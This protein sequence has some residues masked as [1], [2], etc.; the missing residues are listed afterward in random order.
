MASTPD[1]LD[2]RG[3]GQREA[4]FQFDLLDTAR[5]RIGG[6]AP[7]VPVDVTN[8]TTRSIQ[9]TSEITLPGGIAASIDLAH[10]R[11]RIS[12]VLPNA[13]VIA[14]GTFVFVTDDGLR[15]SALTE[16]TGSL[17]DFG[18]LVDQQ[19]TMSFGVP[20][21]TV[22]SPVIER[23][24]VQQG[25]SDFLVDA[26]GIGVGADIAWP[27][28]TS[29]LTI[30]NELAA[31]QGCLPLYFDALGAGRVQ[32]TPDLTTGPV[33]VVYEDGENILDTGIHESSNRLTAPNVF[34]V[35]ESSATDAPIRGEYHVPASAPNSE[36]LRG[37]TIPYVI[38]EQGLQTVAVA[39]ERARLLSITDGAVIEGRSFDSAPDPR[40]GTYSIVEFEG[41]RYLERAWSLTCVD[42]SNMNHTISRIYSDT[43]T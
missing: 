27:P 18:F 3:I 22:I 37:V 31:L 23:I 9:R 35:I 14:V 19:I 41:D 39:N 5:S 21:G 42:G 30:V 26:T 24:L 29:W 12:M 6:L 33:A 28:S 1:L 34:V 32:V 11:V 4:T 13:D 20:A 40:H 36:F 2:L 38:Q 15:T 8:D 10:A 43:V 7:S 16:F 17:M 25:I